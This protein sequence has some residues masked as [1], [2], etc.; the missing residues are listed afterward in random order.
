MDL[1]LREIAAHKR[2]LY[3]QIRWSNE[4][5]KEILDNRIRAVLPDG[6]W[7]SLFPTQIQNTGKNVQTKELCVDYIIRHTTRRPREL[8]YHACALFKEMQ[9]RNGAISNEDVS[10]IVARSNV[11][12][13]A[14]Q[15]V[16]ECGCCRITMTTRQSWKSG[17]IFW[18]FRSCFESVSLASG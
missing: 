14:D 4:D 15:L 12:I 16:P 8:M 10:K 6:S 1:D 9:R 3:L 5:L 2:L 13:V 17:N 7:D 18:C 11:E